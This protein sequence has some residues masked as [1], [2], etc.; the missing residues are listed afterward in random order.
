MEDY[1]KFRLDRSNVVMIVITII[2]FSAL[3][4]A[5]V[6]LYTS[7][8]KPT[9]GLPNLNITQGRETTNSTT[10]ATQT[11][12]TT[13]TKK[14]LT[15][16]PYYEYDLD[17]MLNDDIF[18]KRDLSREEA[19]KVG[20]EY[21]KIINSLYD[22]SDYSIFDTD[23]VARS[24]KEGETDIYTKNDIKYAELYNF[25][26]FIEKFYMKQS[27][28]EF[29]NF[30][31]NKINVIVKEGDKYYRLYDENLKNQIEIV[32]VGIVDYSQFSITCSVRYYNKNYKELGYTAPNYKTTNFVLSYDDRWKVRSYKY[33]LYD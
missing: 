8:K 22:L 9:N 4:I 16:S 14:I 33:P 20:Q 29:L 25:D 27:R 15:D 12:T 17:T 26:K 11:T 28:N 1:E 31:L 32:D 13:T 24:V 3:V 5:S 18:T 21:I 6:M 19:L 10:A 2:C 30:K 7:L 23:A